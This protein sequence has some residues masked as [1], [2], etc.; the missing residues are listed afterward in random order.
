[1]RV[2]LIGTG[3]MGEP[4]G[5]RLL[6]AGHDLGVFN[7][8]PER[9][10]R[11][12]AAGA[13]HATTPAEAVRGR[14]LVLTFLKDGDAVREVLRDAASTLRAG[15]IL[16]DLST[17]GPAFV[18]ELHSMVPAGVGVLDAPVLGSRAEAA[19]GRLQ[20]LAGGAPADLELARPV[21]EAL[22]DVHHVGP[23]GTGAAAKLVANFALLGTLAVLGESVAFADALGVDRHA[24]LETLS[25]SPLAEQ[26]AKRQAALGGDSGQPRFTLALAAKDARL[27]GEA[28]A[29]AEL[30]A[31]V[32]AAVQ[33]KLDAAVDQGLGGADYTA[34]LALR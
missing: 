16:A 7:R 24:A 26:A 4:V 12:I 17:T 31:P 9:A 19:A 14:D 2:G 30:S 21:L 11:L 27:I 22:G 15:A 28:A 10:D 8:T 25:M 18:R 6:A 1:M 29:A 32:A 34:M 23:A 20:I 5:H 33:A 13:Q 3:A